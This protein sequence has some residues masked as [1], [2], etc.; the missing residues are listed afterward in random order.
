ML[1]RPVFDHETSQETYERLMKLKPKVSIQ[2]TFNCIDIEF[3]FAVETATIT[4]GF[5]LGVF[6]SW[7]AAYAFVT[8]H[9]MQLA[10]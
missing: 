10:F 6:P 3:G 9:G 4:P 1:I 8:E 5:W 2:S 7:D